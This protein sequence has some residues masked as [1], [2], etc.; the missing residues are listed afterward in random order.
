MLNTLLTSLLVCPHKPRALRFSGFAP[1]IDALPI[2]LKVCL[3]LGPSHGDEV[4]IAFLTSLVARATSGTS[5]LPLPPA[6]MT[7]TTPAHLP[8]TRQMEL[9]FQSAAVPSPLRATSPTT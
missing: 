3:T 2:S 6:F 5:V 4:L 8:P 1:S 9:P 7:S